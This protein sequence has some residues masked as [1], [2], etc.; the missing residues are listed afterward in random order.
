MVAQPAIY[1]YSIFY[2]F[3]SRKRR[4]HLDCPGVLVICVPI[5]L[6]LFQ[7]RAFSFQKVLKLFLRIAEQARDFLAAFCLAFL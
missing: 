1:I 5:S 3:N 2:Q 7:G 4:A 6:F